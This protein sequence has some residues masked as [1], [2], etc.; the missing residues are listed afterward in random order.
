LVETPTMVE[1]HEFVDKTMEDRLE[2]MIRDV[3]L[4]TFTKYVYKNMTTDAETPLY[5][6]STNFTRLSVVLTLINL[7]AL[8][9][10]T[11]KSF[12]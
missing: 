10:W 11:D 5:P 4:Q 9:G 2:H 7:N 1:A 8:N 12:T 3:G 6:S